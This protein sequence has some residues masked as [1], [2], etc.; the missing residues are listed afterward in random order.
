MEKRQFSCSVV[1]RTAVLGCSEPYLL[2]PHC[3]N[4]RL[5][6]PHG[7]KSHTFRPFRLQLT[8]KEDEE[9]NHYVA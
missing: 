5:D 6:G 4:R 8:R 7:A 2:W 9:I 3:H 1:K